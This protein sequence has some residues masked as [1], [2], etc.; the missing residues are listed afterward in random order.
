MV[1]HITCQCC[2]KSGPLGKVIKCVQCCMAVH[3]G[4]YGAVPSGAVMEA[5]EVEGWLCEVCQNESSLEA[6]LVCH[7]ISFKIYLL[8]N[9]N[10]YQT[11]F[12]AHESKK[13]NG[14]SLGRQR[15]MKMILGFFV[16]VNRQKDRVG[17]ISYVHCMHMKSCIL[18]Q[19]DSVS[20]KGLVLSTGPAG[21]LYVT[22]L[23]S[24]YFHKLIILLQICSVCN[25][26]GGVCVK[27]SFCLTEY[28]P[29]CAWKVGARLTFEM[30][31]VRFS[32][33][34]EI[35]PSNLIIF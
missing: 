16:L 8:S 32:S 25:N 15:G 13:K 11:A 10:R 27:C 5:S 1:K 24:F 26:S 7:L 30:Q 29:S 34:N 6:S 35:L 22:H 12:F 17:L 20:L 9:I 2:K 23:S 31:G 21:R 14:K 4:I 19:P 28:H 18:M 33:I 3:A